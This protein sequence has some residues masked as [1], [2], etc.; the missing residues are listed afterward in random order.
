MCYGVGVCGPAVTFW[1]ALRR[2][3]GRGG[4]YILPLT[5]NHS[6]FALD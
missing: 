1:M 3:N 5:T 6:V 2:E 4:P